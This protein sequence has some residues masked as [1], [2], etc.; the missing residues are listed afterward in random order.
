MKEKAT[1]KESIL[2]FVLLAIFMVSTIALVNKGIISI[3][4]FIG[5]K[6]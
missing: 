6:C 1:I 4:S 3:F 2:F 5:G